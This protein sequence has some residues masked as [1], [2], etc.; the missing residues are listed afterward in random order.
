[1]GCSP[2]NLSRKVISSVSTLESSSPFRKLKEERS[3]TLQIPRLD[4]SCIH[5]QDE[6]AMVGISAMYYLHASNLFRYFLFLS[7]VDATCDNGRLGRLVNHSSRPPNVKTTI[8][9]VDDSPHL[10]LTAAKDIMAKEELLYDYGGRSKDSIESHPWL[11][12]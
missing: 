3:C 4:V 8:V 6:E 5:V 10:I 11:L 1:M 2:P 9:E 7:S 12:N